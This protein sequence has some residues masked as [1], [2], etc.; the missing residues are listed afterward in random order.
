MMQ[1]KLLKFMRKNR[2]SYEL[3]LS[4]LVKKT[5]KKGNRYQNDFLH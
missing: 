3:F 5:L 1:L 4:H 2:I